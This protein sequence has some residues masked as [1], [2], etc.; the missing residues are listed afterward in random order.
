MVAGACN[1]SYLGGW[2]R[3][4]AWTGEAE[5]AMSRNHTTAL[6]PRCQSKTVLKQNKQ[7]QKQNKVNIQLPRDP[8]ILLLYIQ[9]NWK[10]IFTYN[11]VHECSQKYYSSQQKD[12]NPN[13]HQLMDVQN[14][15]NMEYFLAIKRNTC[16]RGMV[17]HAYNPN[18]WG[19]KAS[20]SLA[21]RSSRPA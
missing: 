16:W 10:H 11:L 6:Q 20:E 18:T 2:G 9:E 4:T 19:A 8:A 14:M 17:A 13:V 12:E 15:V 5:V 3:R 7:K 21:V 1:P